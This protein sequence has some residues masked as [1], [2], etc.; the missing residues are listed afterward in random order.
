MATGSTLAKIGDVASD[1]GHL[2]GLTFV[3]D[4][5]YV[6]VG[7]YLSASL[8]QIR[9]FTTCSPQNSYATIESAESWAYYVRVSTD[10]Q[11]S[12]QASQLESVT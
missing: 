8:P 2:I 3:V 11:D 6:E 1:S 10:K 5:E 4:S 9:L 12:G 7:E